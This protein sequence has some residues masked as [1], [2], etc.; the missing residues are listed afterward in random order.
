[1]ARSPFN[2]DWD[3]LP[4]VMRYADELGKGQTVYKHPDRPNYNIT[5]TERTDLY[6]QEWVRYQT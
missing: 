6:E 4:A 3:S 1:M 2:V 5:H